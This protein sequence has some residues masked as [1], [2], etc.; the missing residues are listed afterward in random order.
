MKEGRAV[1][2]PGQKRSQLLE[3]Y[4]F[5]VCFVCLF[6]FGGGIPL[7]GVGLGKPKG[8]PPFV[9]GQ[10]KF[11]CLTARGKS[12]ALRGLQVA[13]AESRAPLRSPAIGKK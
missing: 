4:Q 6:V 10:P 11:G 2:K 13:E 9:V 1:S 12:Q 8:K 3:E 5:N 7:L